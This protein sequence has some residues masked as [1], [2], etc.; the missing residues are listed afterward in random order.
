MPTFRI[1]VTDECT[2][3]VEA[4]TSFHA[5]NAVQAQHG[6]KRGTTTSFTVV[7]PAP[8]APSTSDPE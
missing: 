4:A 7:D 5:V 2:Y 1:R 8:A 3:E 6:L